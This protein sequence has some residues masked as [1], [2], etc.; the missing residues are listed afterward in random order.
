MVEFRKRFE[1]FLILVATD[2]CIGELDSYL[3]ETWTE[4]ADGDFFECDSEEAEAA[5]LHRFAAAGAAPRYQTVHHKETEE[6]LALDVALLGND[7]DWP[8][9]VSGEIAEDLDTALMYGH[10]LCHVF[11]RD[12]IY[13]A[14]TDTAAK[15]AV[16]LRDLEEAGAKYPAEHNVGHMYKAEATLREFYEEL[17][18]TNTFNPGIGKTTKSRRPLC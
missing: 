13:K 7:P 9:I 4:A 14:G 12:Y 11:H 17:D 15:K 2:E 16:L 1:H 6:V 5:L 18:P 3:S 8:G 10:F